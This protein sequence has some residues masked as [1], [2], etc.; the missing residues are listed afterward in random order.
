MNEQNEYWLLC[1]ENELR[2]VEVKQII[3]GCER[4]T[5]SDHS[6]ETTD[7]DQRRFS[8]DPLGRGYRMH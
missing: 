5:A 7:I 8:T 4:V 2:M 1:E 6:V 3:I